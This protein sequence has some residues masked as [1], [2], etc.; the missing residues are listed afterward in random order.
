MPRAHRQILAGRTYHITH[1]CHDRTFLLKFARDRQAYRKWMR[2]GLAREDVAV[3]N[4]CI[5]SNHVHVLARAAVP[6]AIG[7]FMQVVA[8]GMAQ[9][10]NRRKQ[11]SGAFWSDQYHATMIEDGDHLWRCMRY[12]D[13]NMVR[14]GVVKHPR[15]WAWTGWAELMGERRRNRIIQFSDVQQALNVPKLDAFRHQYGSM[16]DEAIR[17]DELQREA[18]WSEAVAVGGADYVAA[19]EQELKRDFTRKRMERRTNDGGTWILREPASPY[20]AENTDK[21]RAISP[22]LPVLEESTC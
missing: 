11:R 4:Y 1:R 13:L 20:G 21:N 7:R 8:G 22:F 9:E 10:Y 5:T 3:L 6:D 19:V 2:Q 12:I 17:K 16:M 18:E 15:E 14:A